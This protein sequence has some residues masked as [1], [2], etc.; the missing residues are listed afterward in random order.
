MEDFR[1]YEQLHFGI[2]SDGFNC[3]KDMEKTEAQEVSLQVSDGIEG[4]KPILT[5]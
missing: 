2:M 1:D 4:Y 5:I 3:E